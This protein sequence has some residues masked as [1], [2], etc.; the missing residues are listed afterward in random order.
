M[1]PQKEATDEG[2]GK[3]TFSSF[4]SDLI[5]GPSDHIDDLEDLTNIARTSRLTPAAA[6]R[7][8]LKDQ[9]YIDGSAFSHSD[10][11]QGAQGRLTTNARLPSLARKR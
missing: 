2:L 10:F 9:I 1:H 6:Q 5:L 7:V 11:G 4:P 8:R 3:T